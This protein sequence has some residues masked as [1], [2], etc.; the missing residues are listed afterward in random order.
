MSFLLTF[1]AYANEIYA[2]LVFNNTFFQFI[3]IMVSLYFYIKRSIFKMTLLF[4]QWCLQGCTDFEFS[5][6]FLQKMKIKDFFLEKRMSKNSAYTS[7]LNKAASNSS[8]RAWRKTL[9]VCVMNYLFNLSIICI[10]AYDLI[11]YSVDI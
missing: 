6:I 1:F 8:T 11:L 5:F 10:L 4:V 9:C 7:F 2:S 3:C